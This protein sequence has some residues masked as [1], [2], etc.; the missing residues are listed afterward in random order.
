LQWSVACWSWLPTVLALGAWTP[1]P[2]QM[3]HRTITFTS[4]FLTHP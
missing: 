1:K 2:M 4:N 3:T